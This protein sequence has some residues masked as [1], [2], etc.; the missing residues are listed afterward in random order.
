MSVFTD[1]VLGV[2]SAVKAGKES[3]A[4]LIQEIVTE[5]RNQS[6]AN[7]PITI[8]GDVA[9]DLIEHKD[10]LVKMVMEE[11][12]EAVA[13]AD[14]APDPSST[15]EPEAVP[16]VAESAPEAPVEPPPEAA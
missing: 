15:V 10:D 2:L 6:G 14:P 12:A 3:V 11:P 4:T 5:L 7:G 16:A 9:A 13:A 8:T 1:R